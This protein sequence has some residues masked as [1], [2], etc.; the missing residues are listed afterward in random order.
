MND[1]PCKEERERFIEADEKLAEITIRKPR[2]QPAV[3]EIH[4]HDRKIN[5]QK[6]DFE[7]MERW[8]KELEKAQQKKDKAQKEFY[9][10]LF[11]HRNGKTLGI[12]QSS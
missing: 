11:K 2:M 7:S 5:I 1:D 3:T 8:K 6:L 10:C 12:P 9:M 4:R